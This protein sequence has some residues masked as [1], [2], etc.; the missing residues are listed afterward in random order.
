M[1][2]PCVVARKCLCMC[3]V[4]SVNDTKLEEQILFINQF[5][6]RAA[7][8]KHTMVGQRCV[9]KGGGGSNVYLRREAII[10]LTK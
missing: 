1:P 5:C 2:V 10:Y 3:I 4:Q 7:T 6:Y 8:R 9:K